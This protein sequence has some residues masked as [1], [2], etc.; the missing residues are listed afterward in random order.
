LLGRTRL[1]EYLVLLAA[2]LTRLWKLDYHS[3]WFD[4]SVSMT[5]ARSSP[6]YAWE[7]TFHLVKDK[8]PPAYYLLLHL[9]RESLKFVGLE[10][11]DVALRL[12][13]SLLGVLTVLGV[14][15]LVNRLSGRGTALLASS[16]VAL[17]PALVW[18]SQELRMFQPATTAVVWAACFLLLAAKTV[19]RGRRFGW[20]L[21]M[22]AAFVLALYSYLFAAFA[23]P[24]AALVLLRPLVHWLR[25]RRVAAPGEP[26]GLA[27]FV[28]GAIALAV[29]G[30]V[31]LPL[32]RN[33]W[34]A[35]ANDGT[36]GTAFMNLAANLVR[37]LQVAT[38]WREDW[39]APWTVVALGL[40]AVLF[41]AGMLVPRAHKHA[42]PHVGSEVVG[43]GVGGDRLYLWAWLG[44]PLLAGNLLLSR[45]DTIFAED[46]YFLFL[47]PFALWAIARG[48]IVLGER[49]RP[50]G[51]LAA[52]AA[53]ILLAAALPRLWSPPMLRE[54]WRAAANYIAGYQ[55]ASPGLPAAA[56]AHVDYTRTPLNWYLSKQ[57]DRDQ[58][59]VFFPFGGSIAPEEVEQVVAPPLRG[60]EES[61]A[62]T[63]WLTQ[64]HLDG[65][66]GG[67][68]VEGWLNQAY[69]VITEQYPTG[70]K[71]TGYAV[72]HR[73]AA[74]PAL[75]P[76]AVRPNMELAPGLI[77]AACEIITPEITARD[78]RMHPPSGWV[79]VRLWWQASGPIASDYVATVRM[80][81][82]E[83]AWG[84]RLYRTN[85]TL[86][87]WPTST[88]EHADFVRD[89]V[90]V[91]LNP[92]TPP[93]EYPILVGAMDGAGQERG[94]TIDCGRV[95]VR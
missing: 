49:W 40:L 37:Q 28:E 3:F 65:I 66:D 83:G 50:V 76:N 57:Y 51:W 63:I 73:F 59:P 70:I 94:K 44:A 78:E 6:G 91:N 17:S 38:I 27:V 43:K 58:L 13:G 62:A 80:V 18:Y 35:N 75:A 32:A 82:P 53:V 92:A 21:A 77:L 71:L 25:T 19:E 1:P 47:V 55:N 9:W 48:V 85:E 68:L 29:T 56:V 52:A 64:S 16:L 11:N 15:L 23:L 31:F 39:G 5:W 30:L 89:E 95:Q 61:G 12:L 42:E 10:N 22:A 8:H 46:R 79:H 4:E 33:A 54:D 67:Q 87:R 36:P 90:D 84:E 88:W 69:P 7:S 26:S 74:L 60:I 41:V 2:L 86:R 81:G 20:W 34:V 45:N 14:L 72:Q 24:A 93:G